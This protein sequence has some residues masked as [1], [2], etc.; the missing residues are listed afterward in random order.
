MHEREEKIVPAYEPGSKFFKWFDNFWYHHKWKTI[1]ICFFVIVFVI[2]T[3]QMCS[4]EEMDLYIMYAGPDALKQEDIQA[5]KLIFSE[6]AGDANGDGVGKTEFID[7]YILSPEQV[8]EKKAEFE[9]AG[10]PV[11]VNNQM[12]ATYYDQFEQHIWTGDTVIC[13]LDPHLYESVYVMKDG[14]KLS[15]FMKLEDVLGKKPENAYDD[16]SIRLKDTEFGKYCNLDEDIL[17]CIRVKSSASFM[18]DKKRTDEYHAYCV[19]VFKRIV[20]F[21][22][23]EE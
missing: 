22:A 20:A 13:L 10:E 8:E 19:E 2:C 23:T 6:V 18:A 14:V 15:G 11:V 17:L 4:R 5:L 16:Y 9:E 3:V 12:F 7:L 1:V 21:T